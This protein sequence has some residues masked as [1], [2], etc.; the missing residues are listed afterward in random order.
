V[1]RWVVAGFLWC[2]KKKKF[3]VEREKGRLA[4]VVSVAGEEMG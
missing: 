3:A 2:R 1:L 4:V